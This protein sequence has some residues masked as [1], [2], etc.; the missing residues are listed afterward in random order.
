MLA[1]MRWLSSRLG[2]KMQAVRATYR[3][4]N[5]WIRSIGDSQW[6]LDEGCY[7]CERPGKVGVVK[8]NTGAIMRLHR[9]SGNSQSIACM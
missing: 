4:R 6:S 3:T 5:F 8:A 7:S 2:Q 9:Q 1:A